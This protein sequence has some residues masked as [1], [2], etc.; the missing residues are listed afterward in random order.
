MAFGPF[1]KDLATPHSKAT[2]HKHAGKGAAP[3]VSAP[4]VRPNDYAK[5]TA[6]PVPAP[7]PMTPPAPVTPLGL[8]TS[9]TSRVAG[10]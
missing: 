3:F 9:G 8:S 1:K 5:P 4:S 2:I 10:I 7:S 6:A